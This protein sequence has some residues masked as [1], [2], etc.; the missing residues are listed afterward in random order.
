MGDNEKLGTPLLR[1]FGITNDENSVCVLVEDFYPYFY[2]RM[3]P[4]FPPKLLDEFGE[5]INIRLKNNIQGGMEK[6]LK[7]VEIVQKTSIFHYS[8]GIEKYIKITVYA[9]KF[10]SGLRDDFEKGINFHGYEFERMTYESKVNF[11]LRYMID[12]GIVGM[13]WITLPKGKYNLRK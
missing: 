3:P 12:R 6:F 13:S 5:F 9:P 4:N 10:V 1:M 11:P 8:E 2:V 7:K